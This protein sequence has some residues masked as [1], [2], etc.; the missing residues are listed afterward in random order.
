KV[1]TEKVKPVIPEMEERIKEMYNLLEKEAIARNYIETKVP[2]FEQSVKEYGDLFKKT[3]EDVERLKQ[4]YYIEESDLESYL[5][6][7]KAVESIA[8]HI[9]DL[10]E[11]I[12]EKELAFSQIRDLLEDGFNQLEK[13]H[14]DHNA[15]VER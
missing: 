15:F 7:E 10:A 8:D 4:A 11:K 3:Q 12:E 5:T 14:E 2:S 1:G 13:I 9:T 6:L